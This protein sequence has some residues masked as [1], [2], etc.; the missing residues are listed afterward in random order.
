MTR[1]EPMPGK[2]STP[3]DVTPK[4]PYATPTLVKYGQVTSLTQSQTAGSSEGAGGTGSGSMKPSDRAV[5]QDIVR[6]GSHPLGFGLYL[7]RYKPE[8][9]DANGHTRQMGVMADEVAPVAPRAIKTGPTGHAVVDY[10]MLGIRPFL[11]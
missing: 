10:G 9:R 7:F 4:K 5:K 1:D 2:E 6:I 11:G 8:F 3:A